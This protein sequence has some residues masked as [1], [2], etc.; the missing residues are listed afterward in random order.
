MEF[1]TKIDGYKIN[2]RKSNKRWDLRI[3]FFSNSRKVTEHE[4]KNLKWEVLV[5]VKK[6]LSD[7]TAYNLNEKQ[8]SRCIPFLT[9]LYEIERIIFDKSH[10][11]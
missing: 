11:M 6:I 1:T 7:Y 5:Q 9:I 2:E 8:M 4:Y 3:T 10:Q